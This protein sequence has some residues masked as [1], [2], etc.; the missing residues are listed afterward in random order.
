M[1]TIPESARSTPICAE[2]D[3]CVVGGSCTGVFAAVRAA[4][5]GASVAVIEQFGQLGG[6]ATARAV[7]IWHSLFD[8]V[9]AQRITAGLTLEVM[10]RLK[11]RGVVDERDPPDADR[12]YT[13]VPAE[14]ACE[15]DELVAEQQSI[16]VF[17]HAKVCAVAGTEPGAVSAVIIEDAGGRRAIRCRTVID[18][19]GDA[20]ICRLSGLSVST[21]SAELQPPTTAALMHGFD[22][23]RDL[24]PHGDIKRAIFS[25]EVPGHLESGFLWSATL[26][27]LTDTSLVYGTRIH[28]VD[29]SDPDQ[30]T[31]AEMA[32][33]RQIRQIIDLLNRH[34]PTPETRVRLIGL[35]TALGIRETRHA[36]GLHRL[37]TAEVLDGH[38]FSDAVVNGSYRVDIHH[39]GGAG[40]TFRYLD[41]RE[42][43]VCPGKP[44][45]HGRWRPSRTVDPTFYQVPYR[46]LIPR[47][48]RNIWVAGRC[49]DAEAGAYGGVRVMVI[50][51]QMGE[52]AGVAAALATRSGQTPEQVDPQILRATLARGGS[53]II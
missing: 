25:E 50:C 4:R 38:R 53:V 32:G 41:G 26:P 35:P 1:D 48:S 24:V 23:M 37:S 27:G 43:V 52:A 8:T 5:L 21:A 7:C 11:R 49:L 10:E 30:L 31:Y 16:R 12:Q 29:C 46:A 18:A 9:N 47:G 14:L 45:Q 13:F 40:L 36:H 28:G 51:N 17:L 3:V 19:S 44:P 33:R 6:T 15:L 39:Q 2:V 22:R 42:S 34:A 20:V